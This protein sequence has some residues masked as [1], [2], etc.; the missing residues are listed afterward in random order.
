MAWAAY[1]CGAL[2]REARQ[3]HRA[4]SQYAPKPLKSRGQVKGRLI[5]TD[6][7]PVF[8]THRGPRMNF[9]IIRRTSLV[10]IFLVRIEHMAEMSLAEDNNMV[11]T[12]PSDRTDEPLRISVLPWR[13]WRDTRHDYAAPGAA[14]YIESFNARLRDELVNGEIFFSPPRA[15]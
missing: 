7:L 6:P 5:Q 1:C 12:L 8:G 11:K 9:L 3:R 13:P 14:G 4:L 10:V 15:P 2:R